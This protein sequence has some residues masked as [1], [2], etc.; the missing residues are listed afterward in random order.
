M[1]KNLR[2]FLC[3][4]VVWLCHP[5]LAVWAWQSGHPES[6]PVPAQQS[7]PTD[8]A[9]LPDAP[10][11]DDLPRLEPVP[12]PGR[13]MVPVHIAANTQRKDGD[14]YTLL[15][16]VEIRYKDYIVRADRMNYNEDTGEAR[17]EGHVELDGG[18]SDE[19]IL[20]D[21]A[22]LNLDLDT[23]RFY[24]VT[25][26]VGVRENIS[27]K[28][29]IYTTT[30]PFLF[31]GKVVIKSG[32]DQFRVIGGTMTSCRLP[33]PDWVIAAGRIDMAD[34]QASARNA[35]FRV[36]NIPIVY[37]PYFTHPVMS[38]DRQSGFL[39]PVYSQSNTKGSVFGEQYYFAINRSADLTLGT[40]YYSKRGWAPSGE[41]RY[42]GRGDDFADIR[43]TALFDRGI[44]LGTP[45]K[46]VDQG[47]Q[48]ILLNGRYSFGPHTRLVSNAEYLSSIIYREAFAENF[49][50][51]TATQVNSSIYLTHNDN[52]ISETGS[53]N[54]YVNYAQVSPFIQDVVIAH[55]PIV[56]ASVLERRLDGTPF[57]WSVD[58]SG[59][60]LNRHEAGFQTAHEVAR[61]DAHPSLSSPLHFRGLDIRPEFAVRET[62]YSKSQAPAYTLN[63]L[64]SSYV[65]IYRS[66][67]LNRKDI[68]AGVELRAPVVER[69]FAPAWLV[70]HDR[71]LRHAIEPGARYRF[72]SGID[73][74]G[75]VL[76]FDPTDLASNTNEIE[77]SVTQRFYLKRLHPRPC[78]NPPLP[79]EGYGRI[80]LPVDYHDCS[81]TET[82]ESLTW[83]LAQK[84]FF[85]PNFGGA[86]M[87]N[88][89]NVL[90]STLD[91]TAIAFLNGPR[92][93]SPL[94]SRLALRTN[95][96]LGFGWDLD[97]D[98]HAGRINGSNIYLEAR[99]SGFFGSVGHVRLDALNPT[100]VPTPVTNYEQL[101]STFGY[102]G[103]TKPGFSGALNLGYDLNQTQLQYGGA[104]ASYNWNCCGITIEYRRLAL[105]PERNENYESFNFTLAG[106]GT[107][108]NINRSQLIY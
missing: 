18:P 27:R 40:D 16:D 47:G 76:R 70:H 62:F 80:Y 4:T 92:D 10:D 63:P 57:F 43:F 83:T 101:R 95:Q 89:R 72:V 82:S 9:S 55:L 96:S 98:P 91:L 25:G 53:F 61:I 79:P 38:S 24:N 21:H 31:T 87:D 64:T 81:S 50:Q 15:G 48:D 32:P 3:I 39:I 45:P 104:Q 11:A 42:R 65:P 37:L 90:S 44:M 51:A 73:N 52:G 100:T 66:A 20:A 68:E 77:Y 49:S 74:F 97:Y 108:G 1:P 99:R 69:D 13:I 102:G 2:S 71:V 23:G 58:G 54:R 33:H 93:Y 41:F 107:A 30:N 6:R 56:D 103:A 86:V 8:S 34:G 7:Q 35:L 5:Q 105:G 67:S 29:V 59:A 106:I 84:H 36:L 22:T 78:A 17:A 60:G 85:D 12:G 14:V 88:R 46:L 75:N 26:S 28:K 19:H 94:I